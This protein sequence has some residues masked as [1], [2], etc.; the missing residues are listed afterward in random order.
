[1][2]WERGGALSYSGWRTQAAK[3][4]G[5]TGRLKRWKYYFPL[6]MLETQDKRDPISWESETFRRLDCMEKN[7]HRLCGDDTYI[8]VI[9]RHPSLMGFPTGLHMCQYL[10]KYLPQF[11]FWIFQIFSIGGCK[12]LA[13]WTAS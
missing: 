7:V 11:Q 5:E 2:S 4:Q 10:P 13:D 3:A 8:G 1:M 6:A 12:W 9:G